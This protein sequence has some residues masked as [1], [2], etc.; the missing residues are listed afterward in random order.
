MET[1]TNEYRKILIDTARH[2]LKNSYSP[3]SNYP[4]GA[5]VLAEDGLVYGGT[6]IENSAY[7]SGLCAE[8]VAITKAISEGNRKILAV[9]VVTR[10]GG[11]PCGACRQVMRE[12]AS[13]EM[14]VIL[15]SIDDGFEEEFTLG[16][17]LPRSFGPD[18]LD[19]K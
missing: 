5:A 9:A 3:Y 8:R 18:D 15:T 14:P 17:L 2:Y 12:F 4:V 19:R 16:D 13:L 1:L 7:P 11:A 10:N 6:N